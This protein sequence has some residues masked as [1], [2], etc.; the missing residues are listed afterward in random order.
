MTQVIFNL[1][2]K[3]QQTRFSLYTATTSRHI[4]GYSSSPIFIKVYVQQGTFAKVQL[5]THLILYHIWTHKTHSS[6]Y[7]SIKFTSTERPQIL[8]TMLDTRVEQ[9]K[10]ESVPS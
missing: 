7:P 9:K 2:R 1:G 10:K 3:R 8:G 5:I 6:I 4:G